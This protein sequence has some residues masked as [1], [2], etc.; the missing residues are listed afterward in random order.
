MIYHSS[1]I[2]DDHALYLVVGTIIIIFLI[3]SDARKKR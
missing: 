2:I 1:N 3:F